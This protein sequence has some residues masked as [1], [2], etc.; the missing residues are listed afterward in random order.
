MPHPTVSII[1]PVWNSGD[2]IRHIVSSILNQSYDDYELLLIDDGSTDDTLDIIK[3]IEKTDSRIGVYSKPNGG[4]SSARNFG[5]DKAK[6]K[7]I[8]FYD[9]D[10]NI[11][12]E[13][14]GTT[15]SA[16]KKS[17][18]DIIVSG[19]QIDLRTPK[20][21]VKEYK[22]I[23]PKSEIIDHNIYDYIIRSLGENGTLY[24][25]W[26]KLFRADIIQQNNLRFREDLKFGEDLLFSLDYFKYISSLQIISDITYCYQTNSSNSIFASSSIVPKF[27]EINDEAVVDFSEKTKS[28]DQNNLTWLRWRW[29][30]S[31]WSLVASCNKPFLQKI[32]L[33]KEFR[34]RDL[35]LS[36]FDAVGLRKYSL[37]LLA[38]LAS[39]TS[40][41]SLLFGFS[42]SSI[43]RII[44][45]LKTSLKNS[46][47]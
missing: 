36:S 22:T 9:S 42:M 33:I 47:Q 39:L 23:S 27:R 34:P 3:A 43:K 21:L 30:M 44:L 32:S 15:V 37:Q 31:Y 17:N 40:F 13:S 8:Q 10:D 24:N 1:I 6:G 19:W 25:L 35:K 2:S 29:L 14:I 41:G 26:N 46:V 7:F 16:I 28:D 4:P 12:Q 38:S 18:C 20:G 11:S 45:G 5:L